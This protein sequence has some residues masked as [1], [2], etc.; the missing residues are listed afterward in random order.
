VTL[1]ARFPVLVTGGTGFVG[2][3]L[4]ERLSE[5]GMPVRCLARR[6]SALDR[7]PRG[8]EIVHGDLRSGAGLCDAVRGAGVVIHVAGVTKALS[9]EEYYQGNVDGTRNLLR[10]CE[11][12]GPARFVHVS[13]LAAIGPSPDGRPLS[14]DADPHPLT[15]YGKSKLA[16]ER[17][18]LESKLAPRAV[19]V[20]PPVVFGPRDTDVFE[21]FRAA[22]RGLLV[23]I[24]RAESLASVIYVKDLAE[25]LIAA[26]T[27]ECAAGHAYF[28]A[29]PKP[30]SW[31][32]FAGTAA[33]IMGRKLRTVSVPP[34]AAHV[35][36]WCAEVASRLRGK[37][38]IVSREKVA[39]ARCPYWVCDTWRAEDE[40]GLRTRPLH[41]AL[42]ETLEWYRR[43]GWLRFECR[44]G[45]QECVRRSGPMV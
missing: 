18:V 45:T 32:E 25:A 15:H 35:A 9:A 39:E 28:A 2:S 22:N 20:R 10:A 3:H 21:I 11:E 27:V 6:S 17:A 5:L 30:V 12:A 7:L 24:G 19:I 41:A 16:A 44:L 36:G 29:A 4:V 23:R 33:A 26:A 37:P 34:A 14:E 13:T 42:A 38:G 31:E 43:A 8:I 1:D 40:L